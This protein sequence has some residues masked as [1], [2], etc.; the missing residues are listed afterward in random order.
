MV[1]RRQR[2][3]PAQRPGGRQ[4]GNMARLFISCNN[5]DLKAA[6]ELEQALER[7]KH[8]MTLRVNARP[9]GRWE[10]QLLRGVHTAD[11][12]ICL[13]TREGRTSSWV[14]GQTGMA[15]SCAH[16][17]GTLVLPV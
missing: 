6:R 1:P 13:L 2:E 12:V 11:A 16:T 4:E 7:R 17:K 10:E 15:I 3:A 5:Q 8:V 14:V 9:A